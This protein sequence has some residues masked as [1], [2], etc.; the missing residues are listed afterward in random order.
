MDLHPYRDAWLLHGRFE[1]NNNGGLS[2]ENADGLAVIDS[3]FNGN[4]LTYNYGLSQGG[5]NSNGGWVGGSMGGWV[6]LG[7][8]RVRIW[9]GPL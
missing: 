3:T 2:V 4:V 7:G 1:G 6:P 9:A 5:D 8:D